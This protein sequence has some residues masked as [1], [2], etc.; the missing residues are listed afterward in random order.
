MFW[1]YLEKYYDVGLL[2]VRI[3]F[4]LGM[5]Y[6]HGWEKLLA[7][8]ARWARLGGVMSRIGIDFGHT[9]FGFM[10]AFSES[11]GGLM[12]AVGLFFQPIASLLC[13]TMMMAAVSHIAS[14]RGNPAHALK[15]A[16]LY[17]ALLFIGPGKYSLDHLL[18][19]FNQSRTIKEKSPLPPEA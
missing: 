16:S 9:F 15:Y 1:K 17:L 18:G 5:F 3:G 14:G 19:R 11:V 4:G 8:P 13:I 2:I 6:F 7:G 10:A 12:I